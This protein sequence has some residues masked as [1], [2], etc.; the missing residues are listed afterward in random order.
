MTLDG[1]LANLSPEARMLVWDRLIEI[2]HPIASDPARRSREL[3]SQIMRGGKSTLSELKGDLASMSPEGRVHAFEILTATP[4]YGHKGINWQS[5]RFPSSPPLTPYQ[6]MID[7]IRN[8]LDPEWAE[9]MSLVEKSKAA[10]YDLGWPHAASIVREAIAI[11]SSLTANV[12]NFYMRDLAVAYFHLEA[13]LGNSG[14]TP[15]AQNSISRCLDLL[16]R[17]ATPDS[18]ASLQYDVSRALQS[19]AIIHAGAGNFPVAVQCQTTAVKSLDL[20]ANLD[21]SKY[22]P[23]LAEAA[24]QSA[25]ILL[26]AGEVEEADATISHALRLYE[27]LENEGVPVD[28]QFVMIALSHRDRIR[29]TLDARNGMNWR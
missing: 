11:L 24:A 25:F 16:S 22:G 28:Q 14:D 9:A 7:H 21:R 13:Y 12:S 5:G 8:V 15:G 23:C 2:N 27:N 1:E 18:D 26:H 10:V 6:L 29:A 4:E 17:C 20:L 19:Q 3:V